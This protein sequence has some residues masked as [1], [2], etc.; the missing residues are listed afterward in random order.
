[1][2]IVRLATVVLATSAALAITAHAQDRSGTVQLADGA[3]PRFIAAGS[4]G[5]GTSMVDVRNAAVFRRR[6]ALDLNGT[7]VADAVKAIAREGHVQIGFSPDALVGTHPVSL[8]S[9]DMTVGAALTAVLF[10]AGVDVVLAA[11]GSHMTLVPRPSVVVDSTARRAPPAGVVTGRVL[12]AATRQ[13]LRAVMVSVLGTRLGALTGLDGRYALR[14]VPLGSQSLRFQRIG[15]LLGHAG[16]EASADS[17]AVPDVMLQASPQVLDEVVTTVLGD[18]RR[19]TIGSD[20]PTIDVD[21]VLS[22]APITDFTDVLAGR[23]PGLEVL[24][25]SG[26]VG[27]STRIRIRGITSLSLTNDPIIVVDGV[28]FDNQEQD[29]A[30]SAQSVS[31]LDDLQSDDIESI[32]VMKGPSATTLYGTD[33]ANGVIV[34]TTKH[35]TNGPTRWDFSGVFGPTQ[36]QGSTS[37]FPQSYYAWGHSTDGRHIPVQ[38]LLL[39]PSYGP[40]I[41][42]GYSGNVAGQSDGTCTVDSVTHYSPLNNASTSVLGTGS[43]QHFEGSLHGGSSRIQYYLS[44]ISDDQTG[45]LQLPPVTLREL[46]QLTGN[47]PGDIRT[48]NVST[49][50]SGNGTFTIQVTPQLLIA[51][52]STIGDNSTRTINESQLVQSLVQGPGY[53]TLNNTSQQF[54]FFAPA[55]IESIFNTVNESD[56]KR[57]FE[58]LHGDWTP[59]RWFV[60]RGTVG[61]DY[62]DLTSTSSLAATQDG[63]AVSLGQYLLNQSVVSLYSVD[64][65]GTAAV[66]LTR[67]MTAATSVGA[68]YNRESYTETSS[69]GYGTAVGNTNLAGATSTYVTQSGLANAT[70]GTYVQEKLGF[71]DRLW[72][73]GAVRWDGGS[74]F[75]SLYNLATYPK[76]D[77][78]WLAIQG[79]HTTLRLRTAFGYSGNQAPVSARLRVFNTTNYGLV[80][81]QPAIGAQLGGIDNPSLQ[82]ELSRELETGFDLSMFDNAAVLTVTPYWKHTDH[83]I[84]GVTTPPSLGSY[85]E[86]VNLGAVSNT[87]IEAS[88]TVTPI[89]SSRVEWD[90]TVSGSYNA[91]KLLRLD[92]GLDT[93]E[94]AAGGA[95]RYVVGYPLAGVWGHR[96]TYTTGNGSGIIT[97]QDVRIDSGLTYYGPSTAPTQLTVATGLA[98][99]NGALRVR[100][101]F[102]YQGGNAIYNPSADEGCGGNT[103]FDYNSRGCNDITAPAGVKAA[104]VAAGEFG[105]GQYGGDPALSSFI[106]KGGVWRFQELGVSY[107]IPDRLFRAWRL[108]AIRALNVSFSVRNLYTWTS[109]PGIDPSVGNINSTG[110]SPYDGGVLPL[111]RTWLMRV[112][113]GF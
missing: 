36:A 63:N 95:D 19:V 24:P 12:D 27:A 38:C 2:S 92:P 90:V 88:L 9:H 59:F 16:I 23:V 51:L 61:A 39:D 91:N 110:D 64:L 102:N 41:I 44:G 72:V 86:D 85:F 67:W 6:I 82:P 73:T 20:L 96:V 98:F 11:D 83:E 111:P 31:R 34:V 35:G 1:M 26:Q 45:G 7:S 47:V 104:D 18:D 57:Y 22:I 13:P 108:P 87:G 106:F 3:G 60:G 40:I 4:V 32:E 30:G 97:P 46:E 29:Q 93:L 80:D 101:L 54:G 56:G 53:S 65:S 69:Y 25:S 50:T 105:Q 84:L 55:S 79:R 52:T 49:H 75:G 42:P 103:I 71:A 17:V 21:S 8:S 112:H 68:Q 78:S 28:R 89:Q 33:A 107:A 99:F 100:A 14:N 10:D 48:P 113:A 15:Y 66:P 76:A 62:S 109:Y 58:S 43:Q 81:G 74:G 5:H 37:Q 77:A 94:S 70:L